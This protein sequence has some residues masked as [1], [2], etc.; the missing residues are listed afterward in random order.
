EPRRI[1]SSLQLGD[2]NRLAARLGCP[3]VA[4]F[5]RADI[6][7]GG[8]GAPLVCALHQ[9]LF[10]KAGEPRAVLNLGG[11][12][13]LTLLPDA[14]PARVRGFDTGPANGLMD[15]WCQRTRG[16]PFDR[17][18]AWAAQGRVLPELLAAWLAEPY[19]TAPA[20]KSTGRGQ[21]NLAWAGA[22]AGDLERFPAADVQRSLLE[23]TVQ[24]VLDALR[25]EQPDTRRLLV[26]GGG[27]R[28]VRLMAR[29]AE[30]FAGPVETTGAHGLDPAWVEATAFA[31]LALARLD[32]RSG[33]LTGVT[34]ARAAAVLGGLYAG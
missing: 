14:D 5:R 30:A 28:N 8:Q 15:E 19:F 10:A 7:R 26:C 11:I 21:F 17:D 16:Q 24:S 12:A 13:N 18:G 27:A 9:A 25:R 34:G 2:P 32:G 20:P 23:L 3:V 33:A 31:W 22:R 6:A 29:L 1:A 4:D